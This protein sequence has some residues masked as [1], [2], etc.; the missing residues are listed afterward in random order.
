MEVRRIEERK[1][2]RTLVEGCRDYLKDCVAGR[3]AEPDPEVERLAQ[4]IVEAGDSAFVG[5]SQ[6]D[7]FMDLVSNFA[8]AYSLYRKT[9]EGEEECEYLTA[10]LRAVKHD[11]EYRIDVAAEELARLQEA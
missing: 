6:T 8:A 7:E 10:E 4:E 5:Q 2:R 3:R 11:A 1:S 9:G